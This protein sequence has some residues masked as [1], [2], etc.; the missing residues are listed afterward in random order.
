M[1]RRVLRS[2]WS[3]VGHSVERYFV[4]VSVKLTKKTQYGLLIVL[5]LCRSGRASGDS[6]AIG[7]SIPRAFLDQVARRL[8]I[9]GVIK[10]QRGPGGGYEIS[11]DPTVGDVLSAM[12]AT[13][14]LLN[15]RDVE[16]YRSGGTEHRALAHMVSN[17]RSH[18]NIMLNRKVRNCG[19]ELVVNELALMDKLSGAQMERGN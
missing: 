5:Y 10:S 19:Q 15:H 16:A 7:L 14:M 17:M 3:G 2:R 12:G 13:P 1:F 9:S 6:M 18:M 11:G 8:R 4:E